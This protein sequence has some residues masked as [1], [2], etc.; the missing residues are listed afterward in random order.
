MSQLPSHPIYILLL[1]CIC[2]HI[3]SGKNDLFSK[4][5]HPAWNTVWCVDICKVSHYRSPLLMPLFS[6]GQLGQHQHHPAVLPWS[7]PAVCRGI[8]PGGRVGG[9]AGVQSGRW[10]AADGA[11]GTLEAVKRFEIFFSWFH[12]HPYWSHTI[13]GE[14]FIFLKMSFFF[15][16]TQNNKI[17]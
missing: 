10:V 13:I 12:I 16:V 1:Q 7:P 9:P 14:K 2:V 4:T 5:V 8:T 11:Q 17:K 15:L 6:T 3:P